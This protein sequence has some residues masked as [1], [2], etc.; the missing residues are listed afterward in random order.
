MKNPTIELNKEQIINALS[1]FPAGELKKVIDSLFRKKV[2]VP[3]TLREIT[4]EAEKIVKKEKLRV[5]VVEEA[6]Q[7]ARSQK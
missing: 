5:D 6:R 1:Q 4:K 3:P 2:F 7:W